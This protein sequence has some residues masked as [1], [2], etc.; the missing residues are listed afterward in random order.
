MPQDNTINLNRRRVLAGLAG[1]AG[2][3]TLAACGN[4]SGASNV[5]LPP[6][7]PGGSDG[8][9]AAP[10]PPAGKILPKPEDSGIDH[11]VVVMME[12]RTFDHMLGWV[13]GADGVQAG[14]KFKNIEGKTVESFRLS[15]DPAYGYQSCGWADPNH[16]Y[17]GG[18]VHLNNGAMD[19]WLL[20]DDTKLNPADKFPVGYFTA[21]DLP[22]YKGMAENWTICDKYFSGILAATYPN[23]VYMHS[24]ETDRLSNTSTISSLPTIWDRMLA[25][26][27]TASY[28]FQDL[29]LLAL[30]GQKYVAN[31]IATPYARFLAEA[32]AGQLPSLS[33]VEPRFLGE[34]PQ[35]VSNDDHPTADVRDGQVLLN[36]IYDALRQ[37]PQWEK[38]LLVIVYDEW[39]GFYDHVV[40]PVGPVTEAEKTLGNDGRLGFRVPCL[41]AG[42]RV[43][44]A[45]C[46]LQFDPQSIL[47]LITWRFGLDKVGARADWSLNLAYALDFDNARSDSPAFS[48]SAP[49]GS[50]L[51]ADSVLGSLPAAAPQSFG[52]TQAEIAAKV[53]GSTNPS[54]SHFAEWLVLRQMARNNGFLV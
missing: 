48:V 53:A 16:N 4:S 13:P 21:D 2:A 40:P 7:A 22:F 50:R 51:C 6:V 45:V 39:G 54:E 31:G 25:K 52:L 41:M 15:D 10:L 17:D 42:P 9:A 37:S 44:K 28:Y 1:G 19:G 23:R 46:K 24:G 34:N 30:W 12:N 32:A 29:P 35:G 33:Y 3:A 20:T 26:G 18:R 27:L 14:L 49:T 43:P 5:L 11:I 47:N 8:I 38:T 36:T